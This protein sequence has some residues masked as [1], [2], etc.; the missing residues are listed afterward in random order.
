MGGIVKSKD[1]SINPCFR[2]TALAAVLALLLMG[3]PA[4]MAGDSPV[5]PP[6]ANPTE[7]LTEI[8]TEPVQPDIVG[9]DEAT[10]G[11]YPFMVDIYM[12]VY[13]TYYSYPF[14]YYGWQ[15]VNC[16]GTLIDAEW[17][18]TAAH[19]FDLV[20]V[21]NNLGYWLTGYPQVDDLTLS[22]GLHDLNSGAGEQYSAKAVFVHR[23]YNDDVKVHDVALVRLDRPSI[24]PP[25][26]LAGPADLDRYPAGTT[27]TAIGWGRTGEDDPGSDVLMEVDLP[28]VSESICA[29]AYPP[30]DPYF[31]AAYQMCAGDVIDGGIGPCMG[32]S[33]GPLLVPRP[34][35]WLQVGV[36]NWG[37]G[38]ARVGSPGIY[39]EVAAYR[40]W[41]NEIMTQSALVDM[42]VYDF[43]ISPDGRYA[44][45]VT[46]D[47]GLYSV[48]VFGGAVTRLG[49]V[50]NPAEFGVDEP[51]FEITADSS[52]V[53]YS[54]PFGD[55][56]CSYDE[57]IR[58]V[59]IAGPESAGVLLRSAAHAERRRLVSP[60]GGHLVYTSF[61]PPEY[62]TDIFSV[63]VTG[64]A[65]VK[66][67]S[68]EVSG[69]D[70]FE[71][72]PD[73]ATVV[74]T[75]DEELFHDGLYSIPIAGGTAT[76]IGHTEV[77][78]SRFRVVGDRVVY[79]TDSYPTEVHS[80]P[81]A[82][83]SSAHVL[84]SGP[85]DTEGVA[86]CSDLAV[87]PTGTFAV[88]LTSDPY[89]AYAVPTTGPA[90]ART[91]ILATGL[92]WFSPSRPSFTSDGAYFL[93][94]A[95]LETGSV[96][97][98]WSVPM[99]GSNTT[100]TKLNLPLDDFYDEVGGF[101]TA[102]HGDLVL[103]SAHLADG[104]GL[105]LYAVPPG[106]PA[107]SG[108]RLNAEPL[109]WGSVD[110]VDFA[111]DGTTI[112]YIS[113]LQRYRYSELMVTSLYDDPSQPMRISG[114]LTIGGDVEQAR[115]VPGTDLV[116]YRADALDPTRSG[117]FM[118][119]LDGT[120]L[121]GPPVA[122][123]DEVRVLEG[124]TTVVP[125]PG[126]LGNDHDPDG[127][128]LEAVHVEGP[129]HAGAFELR[130]DGGFTYRSGPGHAGFD[131]FAYYV[132]DGKWQSDIVVVDITIAPRP[133][134]D[135]WP[136]VIGDFDGDGK[137]DMASFDPE[138]SR[139]FVARSLGDEFSMELWG[140][141]SSVGSWT[142][143]LVG[144]FTGDGLDDIANF[145]EGTSR[146]YVS[147]STGDAFD[148]SL[149]ADFVSA[150][151]W[152]TKLVGDFNGDGKSDIANYHIRTGR[153]YVSQSTGRSFATKLWADFVTPDGWTPQLVG[154]FNGD[155]KADIANYHIRTGRWYISVS[156]GKGFATKLWADFVTPDGW[157]PQMVG[158][159]NGDGRDD[160]GNY[161]TRT[162]RWY[163]S[164]STGT[165][166]STKMWADFVTADGW[167]PQM[168]G[169]FTGDGMDDI[170][171]FHTRTAR[172]YVGIS[173]GSGFSMKRWATFVSPAG[174][175]AQMPGD[176]TGD[177]MDDI[178]NLHPATRRCYISR[179]TGSSFHTTLWGYLPY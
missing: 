116:V 10:P 106:G 173:R 21:Q 3:M 179:S 33:G 114:E 154:D 28:V 120:S 81:V 84:L 86:S 30:P 52:R 44:V 16:A 18:L 59:P 135:S 85:N 7:L 11:E 147:V 101:H 144:D 37:R 171:S 1:G 133:D 137:T 27:A 93:F 78:W 129:A 69:V 26:E 2:S 8:V 66:L 164:M 132:T 155:G 62:V 121:G 138:T 119:G 73:S 118:V 90:S 35:G 149:W 112:T 31:H 152:T 53:V 122:A 43:D 176:F 74:F 94:I 123:P 113:N 63:P 29:I 136:H 77:S 151:G 34:G 115:I 141:F 177:G 41:M 161:H 22:I 23:D 108:H 36:I 38:C 145:H 172:W 14:T 6:E 88:Y 87:D 169:D 82:G 68:G 143:Q 125:A 134:Y 20:R 107:T 67:S 19:C 111:G 166:F 79:C 131:A 71:I 156:T 12:S 58:S 47:G 105:E 91:R 57:E 46:T 24:Y 32:D 100:P 45:F 153:W 61:G 124:E 15:P 160:I 167:Y 174:W 17:V 64:G 142:T 175:T 178:A 109:V 70:W 157:T 128:P 40:P 150:D 39:A 146:W 9:G 98:L 54:I 80:V 96:E 72:A 89:D 140:D 13:V 56:C 99:D 5:R 139:W 48:P 97:E 60:D 117:L 165:A 95:D 103:Y 130:S 110:E 49:G 159:F 163:M 4:A 92:D 42:D 162:G 126:V 55:E 127:D 168:V 83:P 158:D 25:V 50:A 65:P 51:W 148:T 76:E 170:A 102:P 104:R 75:S